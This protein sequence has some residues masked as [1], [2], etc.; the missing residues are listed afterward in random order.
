MGV[1][2]V[3]KTSSRELEVLQ[4]V[5]RGLTNDE[6]GV[7]LLIGAA[8]AK[9]HL[10]RWSLRHGAMNRAHCVDLAYQLGLLRVDAMAPEPPEPEPNDAPSAHPVGYAALTR[11]QVL[12]R[13]RAAE[14]ARRMN[15]VAELS[16]R[17]GEHAVYALVPA[18]V[19]VPGAGW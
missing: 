18:D 2:C 8:T 6:I 9:T 12:P 4:L 17:Q 11:E 3:P 7:Q 14:A 19:D 1:R 5:A 16:S 15:A 13:S 10:R